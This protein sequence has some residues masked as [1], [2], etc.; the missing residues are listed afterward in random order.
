MLGKNVEK[1]IIALILS[2][3]MP[4]MRLE[5]VNAD[6]DTKVASVPS[7]LFASTIRQGTTRTMNKNGNGPPTLSICTE[8]AK[9]ISSAYS[10]YHILQYDSFFFNAHQHTGLLLFA[11]T[12]TWWKNNNVN[13]KF[14]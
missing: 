7:V 9:Q 5:M 3:K 13:E 4:T 6:E 1:T 14:Y 2:S 10:S 8:S 11:L 12:R